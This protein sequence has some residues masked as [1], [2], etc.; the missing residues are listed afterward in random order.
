MPDQRR[1]LIV[2]DHPIFREGLLRVLS[3]D[4]EYIVIGEAADPP[5][6]LAL[7]RQ[8]HPD[9]ILTDLKLG[10]ATGL[11]L[12]R[13][14]QRERLSIPVVML[15]MHKEESLFREAMDAGVQGYI[16]KDNLS[17]ELL[18]CLRAVASGETY[19]SPQVSAYLL[20]WRKAGQQLE[21]AVPG[22]LTLTRMERE[23]LRRVAANKTSREIAQELFISEAT[24]N[25]HRR[26]I[27]AKLDLHGPNRL[28][29]F[30]MDHRSEL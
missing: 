13:A 27:C 23:V 10:Q 1:I 7:A 9:L 30:A 18:D 17:T 11:D 28:L 6:A 22:L 25:T 15:T 21:Q 14:L 16:L 3:R 20:R 26:N 19:L 2:E 5:S 24:V 4:P 8:L 29:R 12:V